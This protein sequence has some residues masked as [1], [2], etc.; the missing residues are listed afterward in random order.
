M[1]FVYVKHQKQNKKIFK[2]VLSLKNAN[3]SLEIHLILQNVL[4]FFSLF[5]HI[6]F[7]ERI[8]LCQFTTMRLPVTTVIYGDGQ[9]LAD[10]P[11][12]QFSFKN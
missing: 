11:L 3:I 9:I 12:L 7:L 8:H 2:A 5:Q 6:T 1:N 4:W 10:S